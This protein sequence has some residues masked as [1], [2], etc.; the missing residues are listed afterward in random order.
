[1]Y[2]CFAFCFDK[3]SIKSSFG[4]RLFAFIQIKF[5]RLCV[6]QTVLT[7]CGVT[8]IAAV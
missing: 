1:M 6:S 7:R 4:S 3:K 5:L 2:F 8:G